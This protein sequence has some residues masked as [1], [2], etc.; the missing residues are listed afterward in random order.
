MQLKNISAVDLPQARVGRLLG[1]AAR[2][3]R[4]FF[5]R[6]VRK[7]I[8]A[9][10]GDALPSLLTGLRAGAR[11]TEA[12]WLNGGIAQAARSIER[13]APLNHALALIVSDIA[14]GRVTWGTYRGKPE[15]L[16]AS[17]RVAEGMRAQQPG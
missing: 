14:A 2:M 17:V 15:M 12:A 16:L 7:Q 6:L 10:R 13:L 8:E 9:V 3:P 4:P 5:R 1:A 11:R